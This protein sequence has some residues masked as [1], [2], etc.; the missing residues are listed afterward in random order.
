MR[1]KNV[2]AKPSLI[3][4]CCA[5]DETTYDEISASRPQVYVYNLYSSPTTTWSAAGISSLSRREATKVLTDS[6]RRSV[7]KRADKAV[8]NSGRSA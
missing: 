3:L 4:H 8:P 1:E 6:G 2:F 7:A 5:F